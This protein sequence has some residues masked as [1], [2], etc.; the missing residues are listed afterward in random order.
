[1]YTALG[2]LLTIIAV[3]N[4]VPISKF[5]SSKPLV[6]AGKYTYSLYLVHQPI[7]FTLGT[8]LFLVFIQHFGYNKSFAA[9]FVLT[10]PVIV[11]MTFLFYRYAEVPSLKFA[12]FFE[13]KYSSSKNK[14]K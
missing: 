10:I 3:L 1:M 5:L 8:G 13:K 9:A 14:Y 11:V 6:T 12:A 7:I 2:A 4:I